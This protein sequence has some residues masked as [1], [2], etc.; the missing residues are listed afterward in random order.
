MVF[1]SDN[2]SA[3]ISYGTVFF[4]DNTEVTEEDRKERVE[5]RNMAD[6]PV[7]EA[8]YIEGFLHN[9]SKTKAE[10]IEYNSVFINYPKKDIESGEYVPVKRKLTTNKS[11][12]LWVLGKKE[13]KN[14]LQRFSKYKSGMT[15]ERI[16]GEEIFVLIKESDLD[17]KEEIIRGR[18]IEVMRKL[19]IPIQENWLE[20][21]VSSVVIEKCNKTNI[22]DLREVFYIKLPSEGELEKAIT[23]AYKK[24]LW[25]KYHKTIPKLA[26]VQLG[27]FV[28]ESFKLKD[29]MN[30]LKMFGRDKFIGYSE[31]HQT[32]IV[33]LVE[34]VG[35][36]VAIK[37]IKIYGAKIWHS[38]ETKSFFM[39]IRERKL[40]PERDIPNIK[41]MIEEAENNLEN[42][43]DNVLFQKDLEESNKKLEIAEK[44][45]EKTLENKVE[46]EIALIKQ[47]IKIAHS[48]DQKEKA[49]SALLKSGIENVDRIL[50]YCK[51]ENILVKKITRKKLQKIL[52]SLKYELVTDPLVAEVCARAKVSQ[53]EFEV[54]QKIWGERQEIREKAPTRIPTL[55]G[56]VGDLH[57][58]MLDQRDENILVAGNETHCC[59]HPLGLGGACVYYMLDN[60]ETSTI[61]KVS[62]KNKL[63]THAQSF[64]WLDEEKNILCFDNI[65]VNGNLMKKEIIDCYRDY[66]DKVLMTTSF[67]FDEYTIGTGYSDV[68]LDNLRNAVGLKKASI[69]ASLGYSDAGNQKILE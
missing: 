67:N 42:D 58:E 35:S 17:K 48:S 9:C 26:S 1:I 4:I 69:P 60:P 37:A 56:D 40:I 12:L 3:K 30:F 39:R 28:I 8:V 32:G 61:F 44:R 34:L 7:V 13:D 41:K 27:V 11:S 46:D 29:W 24:E 53:A 64:T 57:W 5:E 16:P 21:V 51:V 66:K 20:D 43:P 68:V 31:L 38:L 65:E 62:K 49:N 19:P 36:Q 47:I 14:G 6:A 18:I 33:S 55:S 2:G 10:N 23:L 22:H 63:E 25:L 50:K 59:Q 52:I 45:L 15:N 54:Y